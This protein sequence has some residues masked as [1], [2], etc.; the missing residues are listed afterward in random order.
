M[1]GGFAPGQGYFGQG[2]LGGT[3]PAPP[4]LPAAILAQTWCTPARVPWGALDARTT[5]FR[6]ARRVAWKT[7]TAQR[8]WRGP[9]RRD[10][11]E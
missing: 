9:R 6:S 2:S 7:P 8:T 5:T 3:N 10:W 11:K 1:F 4:D